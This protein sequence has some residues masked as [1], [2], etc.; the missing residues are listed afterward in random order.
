MTKRRDF[1]KGCSLG[2]AVSALGSAR[3]AAAGPDA[4]VI[5]PKPLFDI[6][7]YLYM[8]FMEPLGSQDGSVEAAWDYRNDDW[9]KSFVAV[10]KDLAPDSIRFG[11]IYSSY[12]KWREG[13][14][15]VK[16]R[17]W[18]HNY[19]WGGK[20]TNRV[21]THEFVDLCRRTGAEPFYCVNFMSDGRPEY[22]KT[23]DGQ[24]RSGDA[25]EA[26]DWVSYANDPD[27]KERKGHGV[28]QPYNMKLWQLGNETSYSETG[29]NKEQAIATTIEFAKAMR[30]RD[31]SIQLIGW[32]DWRT[33]AAGREL[34]AT[35]MAKR[36]GDQLDYIAFHMGGQGPSRKD[37]VLRGYQYQKFP[38]KGWEELIEI[39]P[40]IEARVKEIEDA[41]RAVSPKLKIAVTEGHMG[42][43]RSSLLPNSWL[44]G[45]YQAQVFNTYQ[46]H[47]DMLKI[48]TNADFEGT[49]WASNAVMISGGTSYLRPV[50]SVMRL[51]KRVN[52]KQ[53]V[54]VTS[55]PSD[56]DIAASRTG[57]KLYLH[58]A[59]TNYNRS[60]GA[61][62]SVPG[63]T[64]G[65]GKVYE[66]APEDPLECIYEGAPDLFK[67]TEKAIAPAPVARWTFP[68]RSVSA[69]ELDLRA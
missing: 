2:A 59:N 26:A 53:G 54:A 50:A 30:Q 17:P 64:V 48:S 8:Q 69:V 19:M 66:I 40:Q 36:A 62:F 67:P 24:N 41:V 52:G 23:W 10:V 6:S 3:A 45:V 34:W 22:I 21:G 63:M 61:S 16:S 55:R 15:P 39:R 46:R 51:F 37:S 11:G 35:D 7:P 33:G 65:G 56:L 28:A 58:V 60:V 43:F 14:G 25:K 42:L 38:E 32:G 13:V 57:N 4:V 18:I 5:D 49:R 68:A 44:V 9:L 29:F 27:N 1:L 20:E 31:R 12:Y 47:G